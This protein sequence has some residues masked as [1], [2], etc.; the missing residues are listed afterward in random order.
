MFESLTALFA[1]NQFLSGG[2]LL[3]AFGIAIAALRRIPSHIYTF[4]KRRLITQVDIPDRDESFKWMVHWLSKHPYHT[5]CRLWTVM[6]RR[7]KQY[8]SEPDAKDKHDRTKI[9]LSPAPGAHFFF[10]RGRFVILQR[11]RKD[12]AGGSSALDYRE[13]MHLTIFSRN[14]QIVQDLLEEARQATVAPE[15][16]RLDILVP[17]DYTGWHLLASRP[18]R[19]LDS[20]VL[21]GNLGTI[22]RDDIESF[23]GSEQWYLDRGLPYRRG[24]LLYGPPGNGKTSLVTALASELKL[25]ICILSLSAPHMSDSVLQELITNLPLHSLLLIEDIDAVF[26]QRERGDANEQISFSGLLNAIDGVVTSPGRIMFLTTNHRDRL[27]PA[28]IR[29]GRCDMTVELGSATPEQLEEMYLRFFPGMTNAAS[30]FAKTNADGEYSMAAVQ[31]HLLKWK[32][33]AEDALTSRI[34][35]LYL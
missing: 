26:N 3:G 29:P 8:A 33:N 27:D 12:T 19:K 15:Q 30:F 25:D 4:T 34:G 28:L 7:H 5:R 16:Q 35:V 20:V 32:E 11:D 21:A 9:V 14:R 6:T 1:D 24:Y 13:T 2:A 31:N 22:L 23:L 17:G 10:Y 18:P